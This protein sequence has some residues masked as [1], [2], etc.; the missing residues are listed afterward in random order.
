MKMIDLSNLPDQ[1]L[2]SMTHWI[3]LTLFLAENAFV[4][5]VDAAGEGFS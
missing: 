4:D 1:T 3:G 5:E 2:V